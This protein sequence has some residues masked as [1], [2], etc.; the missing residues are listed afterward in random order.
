M[1]IRN[2]F[3]T[4]S[5]SSSFIISTRAAIPE[6]YETNVDKITKETIIKVLERLSYELDLE[7]NISYEVDDKKLTELGNFTDEQLLII[8]LI[9]SEQLA[10]YLDVKQRLEKGEKLY[11]IMVDRD[12]YYNQDEL[13]RFV[14][15]SEMINEEYDL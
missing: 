11:H 7:E 6:G 1:K 8:R 2:D 12:W 9:Q 5:S 4:N 3:V 10:L 14:N 13:Q 15:A